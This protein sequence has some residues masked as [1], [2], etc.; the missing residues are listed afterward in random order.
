MLAQLKC[1]KNKVYETNNGDLVGFFGT[2]KL[3]Y[4]DGCEFIITSYKLITMTFKV[5]NNMYNIAKE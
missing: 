5:R 4:G 2:D 3:I 1:D